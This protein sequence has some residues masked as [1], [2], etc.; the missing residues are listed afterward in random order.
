MGE[1]NF[2]PT[3]IGAAIG[4]VRKICHTA[5]QPDLLEQAQKSLQLAGVIDAVRRHDD[6]VLFG[7]LMEWLSY[8]GVSDAVAAGYMD[9]H[10]RVTAKAVRRSLANTPRCPK[11]TSYWA[12]EN[13]GFRKLLAS[14]SRP[15]L[16]HGCPV[17]RHDL[18]NGRLNQTAYSLFLFMRDA[19]QGDFVSWIDA[20]LAAAG[21][22]AGPD[23][24]TA[25]AE[26]VIAPMTGIYGVS[27][28][29][30]AMTMSWLLLTGDSNRKD[31]RAAGGA[32]IAVDTLVHNWLHRTGILRAMA[33][34]HMYGP[35]CY[36]PAGCAAVVTRLAK[37]I[38]ARRFNPAFP[39]QFP[40][41]VQH[42]IWRFCAQSGLN[43]CNG[44]RV[45]D[46]NRCR[47]Y[48]CE[49]FSSCGRVVLNPQ[50]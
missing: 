45:N 8:Q 10:G 18:R 3:N 33:A 44:N 31:W 43:E 37:R 39:Q 6:D 22:A 15:D 28:K 5:G 16:V 49:L 25:L 9:R 2:K 20:Q 24:D 30:L 13:C 41:F 40:R 27:H 48:D 23:R 32:M 42:A 19:A 1:R 50:P 7:W 34:S 17:P 4:L 14:C 11:L 12:F 46:R 38:D 36:G 26:A 47:R 21:G 35:A 29:V